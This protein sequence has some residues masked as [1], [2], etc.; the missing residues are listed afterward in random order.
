MGDPSPADIQGAEK[1]TWVRSRSPVRVACTAV[2]AA[3]AVEVFG[4]GAH[5]LESTVVA[6]ARVVVVKCQEC[7]LVS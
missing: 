1:G 5:C 7:F 2:A 4:G 3:V 6:G